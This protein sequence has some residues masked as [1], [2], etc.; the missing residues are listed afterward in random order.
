MQNRW[1]ANAG[2]LSNEA[3][4]AIQKSH[5]LLVGAGGLGGHIANSLVRLGVRRLTLVD[6]DV[7][8][9]S[10]LNRQLFCAQSTLGQ[11]KA[12]VVAEALKD[13][14]SDVTVAPYVCRIEDLDEAL[15]SDVDWVFDAVDKIAVKRW[16]E[17]LAAR[18]EVPLVHGAIGG[19]YGQFAVCMPG[20]ALLNTFYG[21]H[22][23]GLERQL[24]SPTFTPAVVANL[25]VSEWIKCVTDHPKKQLNT[26][27]MV[28]LAH[29]LMT[30]L[31]TMNDEEV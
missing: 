21:N 11:P 16:L 3:M 25:M 24:G 27:F 2:V 20:C 14:D 13:I 7:F 23:E 1:Q 4:V 17:Q 9:T 18:L 29:T 15:W 31:Y 22:H 8:E 6:P 5:V 30:V 19:W 26:V 28:D 12:I 10:N